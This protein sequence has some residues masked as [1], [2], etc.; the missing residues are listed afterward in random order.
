[1]DT[2]AELFQKALTTQEIPALEWRLL[3]LALGCVLM[4][5]PFWPLTRNL[6]TIAHEGG[7][8]LVGILCGRRLHAIK[9]HTDTSGVTVSSGKPHGLGMI[10]TVAVGYIAPSLLALCLTA[11]LNAG[12][13]ALA[14]L[15]MLLCLAGMFLM[16]R[17]LWGLVTVIPSGLAVFAITAYLSPAAQAFGLL[18]IIGFLSIGGFRPILELQLHRMAGRGEGSDADQLKELT[19]IPGELWVSIFALISFM[20][21]Y[22]SLSMLIFNAW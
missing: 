3:A 21:A 12:Y 14:Y 4:L 6:M 5:N 10:L 15:F 13:V 20:A 9:L 11:L 1:M 2:L 16:I 18:I 19:H 22:S 8:A 17:N 7:H